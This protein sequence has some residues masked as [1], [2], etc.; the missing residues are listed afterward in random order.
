MSD[1]PNTTKAL[2]PDGP[3]SGDIYSDG[4]A[5]NHAW[6]VA[7]AFAAAQLVPKH[8]QGKPSDCLI[9]LALAR[10]LGE[11]PLVVMQSIYI[12]SGKA[13]WSASYMIARANRSGVFKG[14]I[15]WRVEGKGKDLAVTATACLAET[16]E[17]ITF[18]CS[19]QMAEAEGWTSNKKYQSMPELML[20]Y[21]SATMLIRLYAPEVMLGYHTVEELETIQPERGEVVEVT[22]T[23]VPGVRDVRGALGLQADGETLPTPEDVDAAIAQQVHAEPAASK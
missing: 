16:G 17:E 2:A 11:S 20:R 19:M 23:V 8:L 1:A 3:T 10:Q 13:G 9:A 15:N 7:Q 6:R 14:R 12:V 21:R 5:L 22:A 18:T 4:A